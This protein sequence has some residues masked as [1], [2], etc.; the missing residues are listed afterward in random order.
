[1]LPLTEAE[2]AERLAEQLK[3]NPWNGIVKG[4][5]I[6]KQGLVSKRKGLFSRRRML[7]LTEGPHLYYC[8]PSRMVVKGEIPWSS[9]LNPEP[10]DF[11][12]FFVH[13]PHRTYYL[14]D[15]EGFA[16]D[17]CKAI[18]EVRHQVYGESPKPRTMN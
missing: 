6:L 12:I 9:S 16:L 7:L 4:K 5:L 18:N 8:E 15:P 14:E 17:W 10:K 1:M 2:R 13:T 3:S 11:R